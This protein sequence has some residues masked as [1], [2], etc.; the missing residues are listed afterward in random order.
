MDDDERLTLLGQ[1]AE[2]LPPISALLQ[3]ATVRSQDIAFDALRRRLVLM[4]NRYRWEAGGMSRVRA[5]LRIETVGAVQRLHWPAGEMVL[6]LLALRHTA[7]WLVLTFAGGAA[8]RARVE[9]IEVVMEDV[10]APWPT[11]REP[12]HEA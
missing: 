8:L 6:D 5:V 11:A 10:A 12:Q 1:S 9:V 3:D 4:V 2:D 7:D